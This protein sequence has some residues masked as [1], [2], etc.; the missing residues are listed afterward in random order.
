MYIPFTSG[1][2]RG[3]EGEGGPNSTLTWTR[4]S[5]LIYTGLVYKILF[6]ELLKLSKIFENQK[7]S[8]WF[9][10]WVKN[11]TEICCQGVIKALKMPG[12]VKIWIFPPLSGKVLQLFDS[13]ISHLPKLKTYFWR[14]PYSPPSKK[15][16][17]TILRQT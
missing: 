2:G 5:D 8:S 4:Y 12:L 13:K 17:S 6:E 16:N 14:L 10:T 7:F 3:V 1:V 9:N 15:W 11:Y